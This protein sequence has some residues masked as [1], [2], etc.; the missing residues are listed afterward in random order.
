[1]PRALIP[2][3]RSFTPFVYEAHGQNAKEHDHRPV[4]VETEIAER[5]GP[6]KKEAHLQIEND[7]KD[8]DE[9]EPHIKLHASIVEGIKP[10]LI[11]G[12]LLRIGGLVSDY[13]RHD[14]KSPSD[15]DRDRDEDHQWQVIQQ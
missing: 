14:Q 2:F 13:E 8:R 11:G 10:A 15:S 5:Y 4:A 3:K 1:R 9:I 6:G 12:K 7:E